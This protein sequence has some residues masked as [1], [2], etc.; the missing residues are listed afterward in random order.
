MDT[1]LQGATPSG[2][3]DLDYL[4]RE[5]PKAIAQSLEG[6]GRVANIVRSMKEFSHPGTDELQPVDVNKA[7][8]CTLTVCRNEWK[9]VAD[10]VTDLDPRL[11]LVPCMPGACNQVFLNL[12]INSAHAIADKQAGNCTEKGTITVS[13]RSDGDWVEIRVAD[14]GTGIPEK[15]RTK[16]FD[17]FFTTKKVGRGTGQGLAIAHSVI[18]DKHG[19]TLTFDTEV[20]HGT[21]FVVRL[22]QRRRDS[23]QKAPMMNE[24][25]LFVDDEQHVLDALC[26]MLRGQR[27]VWDITCATDPREAWQRLQDGNFHAVVSDISMPGASGLDLLQRIKQSDRLHWV[28]VVMLTGL[29]SRALKRQAL[30][31]GAADLLNKPVDPEDLVARLRNVLRLKAY[32]DELT[33]ANAALEHRV[34]QRTE[35]LSRSRTDV[36]CRLAKAAEYRDNETGNHVIRVGCI[37]RIVAMAL[38]MDRD[39]LDTLFAAAPLHDI[40]KIGIPDSILTKP[41]PLSEQE[42]KVMQQHCRIG[43]K[44]IQENPRAETALNQW[45]GQSLASQGGP[46]DNPILKMAA[47]IALAHHEK[48]DGSGYPQQLAGERIPIEGRIVAVADVFDALTSQRPYKA[49]YPEE[50]A[51]R[52]MDDSARAH[53][54]PEVY[55]AFQ[56]ALPEIRAVRNLFP[57]GINEAT[58]LEEV[59]H[60][61]DLVCGR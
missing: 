54:D 25:V 37:S 40:G 7:L 2:N 30:D 51:L 46:S 10:V 61:A 26:R 18:V 1:M 57:D 15:H 44:I 42:W 34:Q 59:C 50:A 35:Q 31:M 52:I 38:G 43:E 47:G 22:P 55:A 13:T 45:T 60:E 48:W 8:E 12:I 4:T 11:P 14:T 16:V 36:I 19:G 53:F 39:S 23:L 33:S 9:Y 41:A 24:Q 27:G 6:V 21:T 28:P 3:D 17:P 20:G 49:V 29:D 58:S 56:R 5:I 32:Q